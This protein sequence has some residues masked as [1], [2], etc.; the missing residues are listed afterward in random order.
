MK[1]PFALRHAAAAAT[2]AG[3]CL[4]ASPALAGNGKDQLKSVP[5]DV[6][7]VLVVNVE[8]L[9]KSALFQDLFKMVTA[10]PQAQASLN[11]FKTKLGADPLT[12]VKTFTIGFPPDLQ[13]P[14]LALLQITADIGKIEKAATESG[15]NGGKETYQG[16]TLLKSAGDSGGG[17]MGLTAGQLFLGKLEQVKAALDAAKGKGASVEKNAPLAKLIGGAPTGNDVWFAAVVDGKKAT[18]EMAHAKTIRGG[19]DLEKGVDLQL[20]VTMDAKAEA[21]KLAA[22]TKASLEQAKSQP[23]AKMMGL[24][25]IA[26]KISINAKGNDLEIK[27][28]LDEADVNKLKATIGMMMMMAGAGG[29]GGGPGMGGPGG[30]GAAGGLQMPPPPPHGK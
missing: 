5:K 23:Q 16:A 21:D 30:P 24:D 29:G 9:T 1:F 27:V 25:A 13:G 20:V 2:L 3:L 10:A 12:A 11:E 15:L 4:S 18:G 26:S 8:Q 7:G 14:G 6:G 17:A 28:P 19:L 22:E